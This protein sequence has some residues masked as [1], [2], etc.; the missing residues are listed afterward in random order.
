MNIEELITQATELEA[1]ISDATGDARYDLHQKLHRTLE[2]IRLHGGK[3]PAHLRNLD[4]ELIDEEV[5]D[6]FDNM[7]I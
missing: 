6:Q 1:K 7:P 3:V 5:E 2:N 4:L